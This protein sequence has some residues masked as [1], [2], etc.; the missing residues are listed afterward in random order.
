LRYINRNSGV[1][2]DVATLSAEKQ[3]FFTLAYA[4]YKENVNW[5]DFEQFIF[6]HHSPV[7]Q[8]SRRR[9]DVLGDAL[10]VALKDMWL[11]L[12]MKQGFVQRGW[13]KSDQQEAAR[14]ANPNNP[15]STSDVATT[16][17]PRPANKRGRHS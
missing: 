6:S 4:K 3:Q 14:Q 17:A 10:Y 2:I 9:T 12:G 8:S 15:S 13:S 1:D 5:F 16:G 7:F 11:R